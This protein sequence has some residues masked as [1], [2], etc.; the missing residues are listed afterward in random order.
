MIISKVLEHTLLSSMWA[1]MHP[2]DGFYHK[3]RSVAQK[4][5]L[6]K[7]PIGVVDQPPEANFTYTLEQET[8]APD[9]K[10]T[11]QRT[12]RFAVPEKAASVPDAITSTY[13]PTSA[14]LSVVGGLC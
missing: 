1:P 12:V 14:H 10:S 4:N 2:C 9:S 7:A 11:S 13:G 5:L 8:A 3:T 6:P